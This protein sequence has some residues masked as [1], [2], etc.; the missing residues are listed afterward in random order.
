MPLLTYNKILFF[1]LLLCC[2][3]PLPPTPSQYLPVTQ[4]YTV[5]PSSLAAGGCGF[6]WLEPARNK[7]TWHDFMNFSHNNSS[8]FT[9][10][11]VSGGCISFTFKIRQIVAGISITSQFHEFIY[12]IIGGFL[13]FGS[14]VTCGDCVQVRVYYIYSVI[15]SSYT[16]VHT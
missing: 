6:E 13:Q 8:R 16:S 11:S 7:F 10:L 12:L 15:C 1:V 14:T 4:L 3:I 2:F 5:S 9:T